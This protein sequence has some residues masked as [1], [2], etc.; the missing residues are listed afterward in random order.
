MS[1]KRGAQ[2]IM[3]ERDEPAP[4]EEGRTASDVAERV[5]ALLL[6][7]EEAAAAIRRQS[8]ERAQRYLEERM[9]EADAL[10]K[11]R[12]ARLS[13]LSEDVRRQLGS[14]LQTLGRASEELAAE[15]A[16]PS[17]PSISVV[18]DVPERAR[19]PEPERPPEP[20]AGDLTAT[21][22]KRRFARRPDDA[23]LAEEPVSAL[24]RLRRAAGEPNEG[25][26]GVVELA[27]EQAPS[28]PASERDL[29]AAGP[30]DETLAARLVALQMAIA[31]GSRAEVDAHLR[32]A[33]AL[34]DPSQML[35]EVFGADT[36]GEQQVTLPEPRR[37][38]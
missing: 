28:Q 25:A 12:N 30:P 36:P 27:P 4:Q 1:L 6:A 7:A 34:E 37:R 23:P 11:E 8:E 26:P 18:R 2:G 21:D 13:A 35:D 19:V 32:R 38:D 20:D 22:S 3:N 17:R 14:L 5:A 31:G 24:E 15:G 33:F 29:A 16:S 10:A 9:R